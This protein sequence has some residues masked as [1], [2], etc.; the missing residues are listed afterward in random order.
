MITHPLCANTPTGSAELTITGGTLPY[1]YNWSNGSTT[2]IATN[3]AH[4][5]YTVTIIDN[6]GCQTPYIATLINP[7]GIQVTAD[8]GIDPA[9]NSGFI[10]IVTTGGQIPYTYLWS[11]GSDQ[12]N[13]ANLGGGDYYLTLTDA[14]SCV[15]IDSFYIDMPL[16]IPN[17]ITPN[18]DGKNDDFDIQ[19][20]EAYNEVSI[21]IYNRWGD[22]LFSFEG[23]GLE[24]K[25][26]AKRWD[27]TFNGADLPMGSYVY[28]VNLKGEEKTFTGAV[29]IKR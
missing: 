10:N 8:Y 22:I 18:A 14:N 23:T 7:L 19:N 29:S 24:Y 16:I 1:S 4:G 28:I 5:S 25:D 13:Q 6:N 17:M 12:Q 11:N 21:E 2:N 27:G 26:P 3:L 20:I 9:L 15:V